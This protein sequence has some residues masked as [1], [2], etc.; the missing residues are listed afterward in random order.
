LIE[1]LRV[2]HMSKES[3]HRGFFLALAGVLAAFALYTVATGLV[4]D[5]TGGSAHDHHGWV[6][7]AA[8][9]IGLGI[10][11]LTA[12]LAVLSWRAA[13]TQTDPSVR[14]RQRK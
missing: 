3:L 8:N 11:A 6:L 14:A 10:A 1:Q 2:D 12:W 9:I 5:F 4:G 13:R 7:V